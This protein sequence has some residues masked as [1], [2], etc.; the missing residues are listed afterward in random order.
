MG[1]STILKHPFQYNFFFFSLYS[2]GFCLF[3]P[4]LFLLF[5][6]ALNC[7]RG[8]KQVA[9]LVPNRKTALFSKNPLISKNK[10]RHCQPPPALFVI[11]L[12]WIAGLGRFYNLIFTQGH[13]TFLKN[14]FGP[15][16]TLTLSC[17][18]TETFPPFAT[19]L[20][21]SWVV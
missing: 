7:F 16:F 18:K 2:K 4:I 14:L 21:D 8:K 1:H 6:Q 19:C 15:G 17:S 11:S 9:R 5:I 20:E 10:K 13:K 12:F 3:S